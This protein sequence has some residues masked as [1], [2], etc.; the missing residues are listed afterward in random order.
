MSKRHARI[1][2]TKELARK[3]WDLHVIYLFPPGT[4]FDVVVE[5]RWYCASVDGREIRIEKTAEFVEEIDPIE[6]LADLA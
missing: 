5:E 2:L 3:S 1:R 6:R 4:E